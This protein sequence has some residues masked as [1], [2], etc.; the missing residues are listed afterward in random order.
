MLIIILPEW[1]RCSILNAVDLLD[2]VSK[3]RKMSSALLCY[4]EVN[5]VKKRDNLLRAHFWK[6][7]RTLL[8]FSDKYVKKHLPKPQ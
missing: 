1:V 2:A 6:G 7:Y 5:C 4:E 8:K 3:C